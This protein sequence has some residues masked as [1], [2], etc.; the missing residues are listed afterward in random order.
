M[1]TAT[2]DMVSV[3][4]ELRERIDTYSAEGERLRHL[5]DELV[6][7]LGERG[8]FDLMRPAV[9][10]GLELDVPASF[11]AIEEVSVADGSAGWC[12]AIGS[13]LGPVRYLAPEIARQIFCPGVPLAGVL[14]PTGRFTPVEGGYRV[15][16][17][18][19]YASGS[20]HAEWIALGGFV[21]DGAAPR[22]TNG[23]PEYRS[24]YVRPSEVRILDTWH[25]AGLRA[26]GSNDVVAEDIFVPAERS[27]APMTDT[28]IL[29]GVVFAIPQFTF[30]S[31]NLVPVALGIARRAIEEITSLAQGKV[32]LTSATTLREKPLA[33]Y[34][35]ARAEG[36]ARAASAL[37]YNTLDELVAT[38]ERGD[39]VSMPLRGRV[40]LAGTFATESAAQAVEICYRLGGGTSNYETSAL[41]RCMRDMH[42][43]TQHFVMAASNYEIVGRI[44]MGLPPGTPAI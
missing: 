37:L 14:S 18:W 1:T 33:Q 15:T 32:P 16:G 10:G 38:V 28:P 40:R 21:M 41:Q 44:M 27:A 5:P 25:V 12:V 42:A 19:G 8:F 4:H 7:L 11:R 30:F 17:R 26:T 6:R 23:I 3:A 43:I 2:R 39:E 29:N 9:Y 31:I 24:A 13:G 20:H 34:E 35:L 36:L 22:V